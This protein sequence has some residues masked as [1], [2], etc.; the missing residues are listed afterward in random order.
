MKI[1]L[2][3]NTVLLFSY[4]DD[5]VCP[6]VD[7]FDISHF[8]FRKVGTPT[9]PSVLHTDVD[10]TLCNLPLMKLLMDLLLPFRL[11]TIFHLIYA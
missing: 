9:P 3:K 7:I 11:F 1:E 2:S 6:T 10:N 8:S 5:D 4:L